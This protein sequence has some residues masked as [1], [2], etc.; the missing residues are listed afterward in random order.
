VGGQVLTQLGRCDLIVC[1][2]EYEGRRLDDR[3]QLADVGQ[4]RLS[5]VVLYRTGRDRAPPEADELVVETC[6][7]GPAGCQQRHVVGV[8]GS[9]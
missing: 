3:E 6:I 5:E 4:H 8:A 1:P 9:P 7:A 2:L